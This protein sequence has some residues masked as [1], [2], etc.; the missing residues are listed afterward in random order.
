MPAA[1]DGSNSTT[2]A[3]QSGSASVGTR[4][5]SVTRS[6]TWPEVATT[7][8]EVARSMG[9]SSLTASLRPPPVALTVIDATSLPVTTA[10]H[11]TGALPPAGT[12]TVCSG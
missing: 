3:P 7:S 9:S 5:C 12:D 1:S 11:D 10:C 8:G 2:M 6:S 4:T